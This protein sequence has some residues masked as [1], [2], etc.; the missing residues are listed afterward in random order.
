[1]AAIA[2][3]G[4]GGLCDLAFN[5]AAVSTTVIDVIDITTLEPPA[6]P[7]AAEGG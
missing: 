4:T 1:V 5:P 7:A 2:I 6:T 3:S